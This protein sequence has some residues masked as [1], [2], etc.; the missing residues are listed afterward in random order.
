[1]IWRLTGAG[2]VI[3]G[4]PNKRGSILMKTVITKLPKAAISAPPIILIDLKGD[5]P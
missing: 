1:M 5:P 3:W 4:N 2:E